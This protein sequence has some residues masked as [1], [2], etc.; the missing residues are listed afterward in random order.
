MSTVFHRNS[1]NV[2]LVSEPP[3]LLKLRGIA[4]GTRFSVQE[5]VS[6]FQ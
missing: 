4:I 6:V 1:V 5:T 3:V 2:L